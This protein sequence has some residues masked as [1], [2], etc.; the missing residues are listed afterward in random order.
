MGSHSNIIGIK[1]QT[2]SS[3]IEAIQSFA[4]SVF[5]AMEIDGVDL[6]RMKNEDNFPMA[7]FIANVTIEKLLDD[8]RDQVPNKCPVVREYGRKAERDKRNKRNDEKKID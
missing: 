2:P 8:I 3:F 1:E 4:H 6:E 7:F 5:G